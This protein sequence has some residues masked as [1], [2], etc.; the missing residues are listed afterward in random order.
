[1]RENEECFSQAFNQASTL[2]QNVIHETA[3]SK[4]DHLLHR[5]ELDH[6]SF[7]E[8]R[9][10][11]SNLRG[12]PGPGFGFDA[13]TGSIAGS[14]SVQANVG[15]YGHVQ[16]APNSEQRL[17]QCRSLDRLNYPLVRRLRGYQAHLHHPN[18]NSG[19]RMFFNG[20]DEGSSIY[21][22]LYFKYQYIQ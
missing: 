12:D 2:V 11:K 22:V 19:W 20:L 4:Y 1:M 16:G 17:A 9:T 3:R 8:D 7:I 14:V 5:I 21:Y 13:I 15:R 6:Y 10:E 18:P